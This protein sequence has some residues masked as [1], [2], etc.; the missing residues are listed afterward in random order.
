MNIVRRHARVLANRPLAPGTHELEF[1]RGDFLFRAGEEIIVHA[2]H[3]DQDRTYSL[4]S[5]ESDPTLK[6]L[7]REIPDGAVSPQLVRLP[8]GAVLDYS[9]PTGSFVLRD[10]TRPIWF[11]AT[12]TGIAPLLSFLRSDPRLRPVVLHGVQ[13]ATERYAMAEILGRAEAYHP[14]LSRDP[15]HPARRVTDALAELPLSPH[16]DY[17]L[18]GGQPMIREARELL[19]AR[20][21][22]A[23]R[24]LAE[25]Y[26]YW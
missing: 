25:P 14:C 10:R 22:D 15:D 1:E 21:I 5:G 11:I 4:A 3:A 26:Y 6:L 17:Y 16:A 23:A 20:G 8:A 9:G 2:L 12:G 13:R 24:I 7:I 18:C 19:L